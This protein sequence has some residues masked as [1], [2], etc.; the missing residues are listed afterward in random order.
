M[1]SAAGALECPD[2]AEWARLLS[3]GNA[4]AWQE[5]SASRE[6]ITRALLAGLPVK[7]P[8]PGLKAQLLAR[9]ARTD[10][11]AAPRSAKPPPFRT[12]RKDEGDWLSLPFPGIRAK[13]LSCDLQRNYAWIYA[14]IGAGVRYPSH[15]HSAA[16]ELY[17]LTGDLVVN[18]TV[19]HAGDFHHAE[20]D[21]DHAD[22]A[23]VDGCTALMLV[24]IDALTP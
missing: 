3:E 18:G 8:R 16:E 10:G 4:L 17:V 12:Q 24:P 19:L 13:L 9:V 5:L 1:L 6:A 22:V 23:S 21:T 20:A 15:H 11:D 14:E 7:R 2:A